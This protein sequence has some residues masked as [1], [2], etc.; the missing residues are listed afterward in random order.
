MTKKTKLRCVHRHTIEEHPSCFAKGL[1]QE[2]E[3]KDDREW[4]RL[5]KIPWYKFPGYRIGYFDIETDGLLANFGTMLTWCI[6]EKGGDTKY[7]VITKDELFNGTLDKRLTKEFVDEI[8][9]YNIIVGYYSTRFDL[10]FVRTKALHYDLDFPGYGEIYHWDLY[11]TVRAKLCLNRNTL[12]NA[13]E[14]LHIDGKTPIDKNVWRKAKYGNVKAL[15][16][17]LVHNLADVEI[18][19]KLHDKLSFAR[20]WIRGSV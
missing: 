13:C 15:Q 17:V 4:E 5:T 8:S 12:D 10:P 11:Y 1:I 9:N 18:L 14:F 7:S 20:K 3:F 6:K 16:T 19:E 2:Y